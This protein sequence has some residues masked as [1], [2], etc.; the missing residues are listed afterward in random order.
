M[1]IQNTQ[2]QTNSRWQQQSSK[3]IGLIFWLLLLGCYWFYVQANGLTVADAAFE[4]TNIITGTVFG[5]LIFILIYTLRP[6][7]FFPSLIGT[8]LGGFLFGPI[9]AVYTIV[10]GNASA[11]VAYL[12]GR[13]FSQGFLENDADD[14]LIQRYSGRLRENSFETILIMRLIL[15]PYDFVSYACGFLKINWQAFLLG[16][17]IGS[18][19]GTISFTYLGTS[20]GTL[21]E[22]LN[23]EVQADPVAFGISIT[24]ILISLLISRILKHRESQP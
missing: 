22:L 15:L 4:L 7:I 17:A 14:T 19:V 10:G 6:L 8:M 9:G 21:D 23:G 20:F 5:P 2:S 3:L 12:I 11:M 24:L 16:T 18:V 13:F 1:T